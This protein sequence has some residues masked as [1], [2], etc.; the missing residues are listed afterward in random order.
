MPQRLLHGGQN[1]GILPG[2][3]IDDPVGVEPDGGEGRGEKVAAAEAPEDD[4]AHPCEEAPDEQGRGR[5]MLALGPALDEFMH[6][7]E[8]Q[9]A[10]GEVP[11]ERLDLEGQRAALRPGRAVESDDPAAEIGQSDIVPGMRHA[12]LEGV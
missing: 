10:P 12:L 5:D 11:I 6:L 3:D 1:L 9:P 7:P 4:A 8:R 2:L